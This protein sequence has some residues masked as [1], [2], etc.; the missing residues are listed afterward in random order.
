MPLMIVLVTRLYEKH[1]LVRPIIY[2]RGSV[3]KT[4]FVNS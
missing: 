4:C 3:R 1:S 2:L